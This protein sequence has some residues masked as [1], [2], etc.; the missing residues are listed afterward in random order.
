M[1]HK[2]LKINLTK[3]L[4]QHEIQWFLLSLYLYIIFIKRNINFVEIIM[5][6]CNKLFL[7]IVNI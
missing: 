5:L 3:F 4:L 6:V 1:I 2:K 7:L